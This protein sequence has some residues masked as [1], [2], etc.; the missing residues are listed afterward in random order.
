[1][2]KKAFL[3][4]LLT[5][6]AISCIFESHCMK[7]EKAISDAI[8]SQ[9]CYKISALGDF[10]KVEDETTKQNVL[11][12]EIYCFV[13]MKALLMFADTKKDYGSFSS[14]LSTFNEIVSFL[15]TVDVMNK[16]RTSWRSGAISK[17]PFIGF[18]IGSYACEAVDYSE[19]MGTVI[20]SKDD[21][22]TACTELAVKIDEQ[23]SNDISIAED[24][25]LKDPL[26]IFR[27]LKE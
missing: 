6:F 22:S 18:I 21:L 16:S 20:S 15:D 9:R 14:I 11:K 17:L 2:N 8:S 27:K 4:K 19:Y 10:I 12:A 13:Y 24:T 5:V 7:V 3:R 26:I 25:I 23:L 1:M